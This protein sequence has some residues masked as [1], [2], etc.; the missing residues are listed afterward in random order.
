LVGKV[1]NRRAKIRYGSGTTC[2][3]TRVTCA[4]CVGRKRVN[5]CCTTS[6]TTHGSSITSVRVTRV[7]GSW[8]ASGRGL[9]NNVATSSNEVG[10]IA[11]VLGN[12]TTIN[13]RA[14]VARTETT[15][16]GAS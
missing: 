16:S 10:L 13:R 15:T 3:V 12:I 9:G 1:A 4:G 14:L 5:S 8:D 2:W 11:E 6:S 7:V